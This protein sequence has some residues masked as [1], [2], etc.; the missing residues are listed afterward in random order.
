MPPSSTRTSPRARSGKL[1]GLATKKKLGKD[2]Y[3][4]IGRK[5]GKARAGK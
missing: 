5:G 4:K 1:G 2:H 3:V